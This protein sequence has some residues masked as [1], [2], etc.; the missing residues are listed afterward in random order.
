MKWNLRSKS[1]LFSKSENE[2]LEI[3]NND[4][5]LIRPIATSNDDVSDRLC[6]HTHNDALLHQMIISHKKGKYI[7]PHRVN[8]TGDGSYLILE[9]SMDLITFSDS[10]RPEQLIQLCSYEKKE[11]FFCRLP[12]VKF[13]TQIL[14]EDT[15]FIETRLGPFRESEKQTAD[16][17]PE[18]R[19]IELVDNYIRSLSK[20]LG[21][22]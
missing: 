22:A 19:N 6:A 7:Q 13:R 18:A 2:I 12:S 10:G 14:L 3:G 21:I 20:Q 9:G 1:A 11:T 17:A 8:A 15:L 16:W 4:L 5:N